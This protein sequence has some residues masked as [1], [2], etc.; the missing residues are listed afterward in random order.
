MKPQ[1]EVIDKS[2]IRQ[3]LSRKKEKDPYYILVA[4]KSNGEKIAF[5]ADQRGK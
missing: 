5:D 1:L 3:S 4:T 2:V